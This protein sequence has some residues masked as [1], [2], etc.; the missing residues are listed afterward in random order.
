MVGGLPGAAS[1][2][3]S[4]WWYVE[5]ADPDPNADRMVVVLERAGG[6]IAVEELTNDSK[7]DAW[8]ETTFDLSPYAGEA[9]SLTFH[10]ETDYANPTTFYVDDVEILA[11]GIEV[12][13]APL[14]L[15]M[16]LKTRGP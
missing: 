8:Y 6:Q 9:L 16:V 3:L 13:D 10:A 5:S 14:Y 7:R 2:T 1:I 12:T 11:C 15:P 4:Y